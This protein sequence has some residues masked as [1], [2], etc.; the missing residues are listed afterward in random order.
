[1]GCTAIEDR[2]QDRV[3]ETIEY[4]RRAGM[5]VWVL[6]GDKQSTA[7]SIGQSARLIVPGMEVLK[8]NVETEAEAAP[9]LE[10]ALAVARERTGA[11]GAAAGG[12]SRAQVTRAREPG[13][14]ECCLVV[15]GASLQYTLDGSTPLFLSLAALCRSVIICRVTP[16]QKARVVSTVQHNLH[17]VSLAIGDGANDVAMIQKAH[18]GVGVLG[19]EGTQAARAADY[20]ISQF[21]HLQRL[22]CVHGRY[23]YIRTV[24]LIKYSFYKNLAFTL[25]P[26]F[27]GLDCAYTGQTLHDAWII[28]MYNMVLTALPPLMLGLFEKDVS[29]EMIEAN[30]AL[31]KYI[32]SGVLFDVKTYFLWLLNASCHAALM[33]YGIRQA[34]AGM[35][36]DDRGF[37]AAQW[38]MSICC[39][40]VAIFVVCLKSGLI[41]SNWVVAHHIAVWGSIIVFCAFVLVYTSTWT[42]PNVY[43]VVVDA[44]LTPVGILSIILTI[45]GT[46]LTDYAMVA[47]MSWF[48][49]E[50]YHVLRVSCCGWWACVQGAPLTSGIWLRGGHVR[51]QEKE[52]LARR[53]QNAASR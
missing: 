8:I 38:D 26:L 49:P 31:Y 39:S 44:V 3:P 25:M 24:K 18:V 41:A 7:I 28:T 27:F 1:V 21:K 53:A 43:Y 16:A 51:A 36:I 13:T 9:A 19:R 23:S 37:V 35:I 32:Q 14:G 33:Y 29:Q 2:L 20:A 6:T 47:F 22:L 10:R 46:M 50:D 34:Y 4:L 5:N 15:D 11:G 17:K 40:T 45:V 42:M 52:V 48:W 30:P 12:T